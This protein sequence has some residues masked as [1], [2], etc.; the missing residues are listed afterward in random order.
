MI[1]K[2]TNDFVIAG[3]FYFFLLSKR[4]NDR[5]VNRNP[6]ERDKILYIKSKTMFMKIFQMCSVV[7]ALRYGFR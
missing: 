4:F 7:E 3:G 1:G 5:I 2:V 6:I